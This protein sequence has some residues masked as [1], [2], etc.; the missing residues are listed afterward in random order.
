MPEVGLPWR[1]QV[2]A[3]V[4]EEAAVDLGRALAAYKKAKGTRRKVGFPGFAKKHQG[5]QTF[6]LRNKVS[7]TGRSCIVVGEGEP[8]SITLPVIGSLR[9]REDTR[10]LR[11]L[12][13]RASGVG[14]A[15]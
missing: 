9:L 15:W 12:C 10:R 6:R 5:A 8:R 4:F 7:P 11:R 2:C 14:S 13:S 1:S 3:Q